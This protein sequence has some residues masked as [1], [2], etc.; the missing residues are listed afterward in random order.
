MLQHREVVVHRNGVHV[1][2]SLRGS[3]ARQELTGIPVPQ[4]E[5]GDCRVIL[6]V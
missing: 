3:N 6:I 4:L 1:P 2:P 5:G